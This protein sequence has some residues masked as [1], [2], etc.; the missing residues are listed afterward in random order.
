VNKTHKTKDYIV[1][2]SANISGVF[3]IKGTPVKL[4]PITAQTYLSQGKVK[5][6]PVKADTKANKASGAK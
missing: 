3:L 6:A 2:K 4:S 5:P 1:T